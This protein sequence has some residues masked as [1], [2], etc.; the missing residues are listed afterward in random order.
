MEFYIDPDLWVTPERGGCPFD[1][2]QSEPTRIVPS[3]GKWVS[4]GARLTE[5]P[6]YTGHQE[7]SPLTKIWWGK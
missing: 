1:S 5:E 6:P 2:P 7:T 3:R 4:C